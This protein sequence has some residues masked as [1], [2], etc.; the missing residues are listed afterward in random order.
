MNTKSLIRL[1]LCLA[2]IIV[3]V[4]SVALLLVG[5]KADPQG[6]GVW[7][8]TGGP[9]LQEGNIQLLAIDQ[10][11]EGTAYAMVE[12]AGLRSLYRTT[13]LAQSWT[14]VHTFKEPFSSLMISGT[15]LYLGGKDI[16]GGSAAIWR[17]TDSGASWT[18]VYTATDTTHIYSFALAGSA[19]QVY[20]AIS[21]GSNGLLLETDNGLDWV[22]SFSQPGSFQ[23]VA[24]AQDDPSQVFAGGNDPSGLA[25]VYRSLNSGQDWSLIFSSDTERYDGF[26]TIHPLNSQVIF[27]KTR[28]NGCCPPPLANLWRSTNGGTDWNI[29][30]TRP[31]WGTVFARPD[32]IYNVTDREYTLEASAISPT[33]QTSSIVLPEWG[34]NCIAVEDRGV[35]VEQS[36]LITQPLVYIGF[37]IEGLYTS[38]GHLENIQEANTGFHNLLVPRS[39][40]L[41]LQNEGTLYVATDQDGFKSTDGG[42]TWTA[43][44][45]TL[46]PKTFSV[47]PGQSNEVL[48]GVENDQGAGDSIFHSADGSETWT[49]VYSHYTPGTN[50]IAY[51]VTYDPTDPERAF[52]VSGPWSPGNPISTTV[53]TSTNSG[54]SWATVMQV[55][56]FNPG[57]SVLQ[58]DPEGIV[59]LAGRSWEPPLSTLYRSDDHGKTWVMKYQ[60][61]YQTNIIGLTFDPHCPEDVYM[62]ENYSLL[63]STDRGET[64]QTIITSDKQLYSIVHDPLIPGKLYLGMDGP[65]VWMSYDAGATWLV[66]E[67]WEDV[68]AA[69]QVISLA[70][71]STPLERTL[72]GGLDGVWTY[73]INGDEGTFTPEGGGLLTYI[74]PDGITTTIQA[75]ADCVSQTVTLLYMP[76]IAP[77][78]LITPTGLQFAGQA[79]TLDAYAGDIALDDFAFSQPV[80]VTL[81][82]NQADM[83]GLVE[84]SLKLD[85]WKD[86]QWLDVAATCTPTSQYQR[87]L[88]ENWLSVPICHLSYFALLG[89]LGYA[90]FIP[91]V[92]R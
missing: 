70:A 52:A 88:V 60:G 17:S 49:P 15:T 53:L 65:A 75:G 68:M 27:V 16:L 51:D 2:V 24:V 26:L 83:I 30:A 20:A 7:T 14:L 64:W 74:A 11:A 39:I 92:V 8:P 57:L 32:S 62:I 89:N 35:T 56:G 3:A 71:N 40:T 10:A 84:S 86:G 42:M 6:S 63:K 41:D 44:N 1:G 4:G 85:V 81:Y 13:D 34:P 77:G 61:E 5:V 25:K 19:D 22:A 31:F 73:T 9:W 46:H 55:D 67:N 69:P 72:Y 54:L 66:L 29:I 78:D 59:Y 79:F 50:E 23:D 33:W 38:L 21:S 58:V 80:T 76:A 48:M 90:T 28:L 91:M 36:Q 12:A 87:N 45:L 18:A 47:K 82:Y 43:M 37:P